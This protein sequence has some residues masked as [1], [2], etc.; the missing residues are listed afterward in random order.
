MARI[1]T[2]SEENLERE[3]K[4]AEM[5]ASQIGEEGVYWVPDD[6][7]KP[8]LGPLENRP[9]AHIH[10]QGRMMR[11]MVA[12]YQYAG[13]PVWKER[14]DRMVD[15]I[16]RQ[17]VV[18]KDD[19]AYFPVHGWM[20]EEYFRS[21]YIKDRGWKDTAEPEDEKAGEEGSMFN[22]Q[23]HTPGVLSNWYLMTGNKQA[24]R[25][26]GEL[27]RFLT[28]PKFW[29]DWKEGEYPSVIGSEHAHWHGHFYG[30]VNTLR[31]ILEYA[32]ATNDAQLK[33][34]VR[35]G[36]EWARQP[37]LVARIGIGGNGQ[38]CAIPRMI[39]LAIKLSDAGIGDYWE[40]VD[41]YI[42]NHGTEMQFTPEDIPY[43][44]SFGERKL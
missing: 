7:H 17:L 43:L 21:C 33:A 26:A 41:L 40:D 34:F 39:G 16:D 23:G 18:H 31:A 22:H 4:M 3:A 30:H 37:W 15:G 10:S 14:V 11:P 35:D 42:R 25:L 24:L 27:V 12:W 8:W 36:Y 32:I 9:F 19:Y 6:P 29:A 2:G 13:D 44:E 38:G 28:K 1:M 5:L 20:D